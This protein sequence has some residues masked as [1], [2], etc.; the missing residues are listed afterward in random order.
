MRLK[1]SWLGVGTLFAAASAMFTVITV[2][3]ADARGGRGG[4]FGSRGSKTYSA[5]PATKTA[6]A[7]AQPVGKSITQPGKAAPAAGAAAGAGAAAAAKPGMFGGMG[8]VKGLLLGGLLG[9]GLAGIF[10]AGALANV[11]GFLLQGLL[12]AAVVMLVISLF[13]RRSGQQPAMAT[14]SA[15][16]SPAPP[17]QP[18]ASYRSAAAMAPAAPEFTVEPADFDA[19]QQLL[20]EIQLAYGRGD[21]RTLETRLTP[22][23]LSYFAEELEANRR[24]GV[25]NEIADVTLLEG[26]LAESWREQGGEYATV[27]MRYS[28]LDVTVEVASGR[29][30]EG[31]RT[32]PDEAT[33]LWTF[34]RPIGGNAGQWEL[35]A[36]QQ[37]S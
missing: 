33:E 30:V 7:A 31:S 21:M 2:D 1:S 17:Q 11:L 26:D 18:E 5:P 35:S 3:L 8:M 16:Q 37:T 15:G 22:E 19:F 12:I 32:Q 28:L 20:G 9:A 10:G 4:S 36:I 6:P 27:A 14:A 13:R 29:V 34:W 23:M 24:N 25:R